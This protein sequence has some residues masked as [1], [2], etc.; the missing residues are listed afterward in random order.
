[1]K[2]WLII[3]ASTNWATCGVYSKA[4]VHL[5]SQPAIISYKGYLNVHAMYSEFFCLPSI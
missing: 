1:M 4:I 5:V 3:P 2:Q